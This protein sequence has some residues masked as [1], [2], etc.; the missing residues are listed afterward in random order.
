MM[1]CVLPVDIAIAQ[2]IINLLPK[3]GELV[4][5]VSEVMCIQYDQG[6]AL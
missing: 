5:A 2:K 3:I 1:A 6:L 4:F